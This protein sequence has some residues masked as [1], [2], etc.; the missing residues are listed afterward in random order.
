MSQLVSE[1]EEEREASFSF[2]EYSMI[3]AMRMDITYIYNI[4]PNR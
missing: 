4:I 3:R 1:A 2:N